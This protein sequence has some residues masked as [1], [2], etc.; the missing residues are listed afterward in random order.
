MRLLVYQDFSLLQSAVGPTQP[1][2]QWVPGAPSPEVKDIGAILPL[3]HTSSLHNSELIKHRG[4]FTFITFTRLLR[5]C[6]IIRRIETITNKLT[7]FISKAL[8]VRRPGS[9]KRR[10]TGSPQHGIFIQE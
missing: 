9:P 8:N 1:L 7:F 3:P 4:V 6:R 5:F 10:E 2:I